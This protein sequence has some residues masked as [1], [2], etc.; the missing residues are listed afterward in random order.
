MWRDI[1]RW[2]QR[3]AAIAL[4]RARAAP[5]S[6]LFSPIWQR[7]PATSPPTSNPGTLNIPPEHCRTDA[8]PSAAPK[9]SPFKKTSEWLESG[10]LGTMQ[11][12]L[13]SSL[14]LSALLLVWIRR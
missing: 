10:F 13:P 11:H 5:N 2:L 6:P 1:S 7:E 3:P 4:R 9:Y 8:K 12:I 14:I